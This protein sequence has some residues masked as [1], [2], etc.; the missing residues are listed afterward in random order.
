MRDFE[1]STLWRISAFERMRETRGAFDSEEPTLLPTT[2]M[3]DLDQLRRDPL[4]NDVLEVVAACL[5]H[6]EP[7]LLYLALGA[8][9]W[10]LTLFPAQWLAHSSQDIGTLAQVGELVQ[11][12]L[13]NAERPGVRPPGHWM[14]ER[15]ADAERYRSL[16]PILWTL[17]MEG[18]RHALLGEIGG[19]AAYRI[20]S[21]GASERPA[22]HGA[23][24]SAMQRLR[25]GDAVPLRE[26]AAWPGMSVDRASRL[27]NALYLTGGLLVT[28]SHPA[29]REQPP[30]QPGS[31]H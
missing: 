14:I 26:I 18:P 10:P 25:Y 6:R 9:V 1:H 7:A 22:T 31:R 3:A 27:L 15:I 29:A 5:R 8:F 19:R 16:R 2:L 24:T 20:T 11:L 12:K 17:A 30:R 13:I 4:S 23:L 21:A 28:R